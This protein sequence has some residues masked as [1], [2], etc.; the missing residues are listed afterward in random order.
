MNLWGIIKGLLVQDETDRSK[1]LSLEVDPTSTTGTKT[2]LK[3]AQTANRTLVLPD[4]SGTLVEQATTDA[5]DGR[6]DT[7]ESNI[8]NLQGRMT[9]AEGNITTNATN[10]SNHLAD[11]TDAHDASAISADTSGFLFS[12]AN[13]VQSVL[14]QLDNAIS[15]REQ[16][17][18]DHIG[19]TTNAHMASAVG[20]VPSGNLS[21]TTVQA[22]LNELQTE[23]DVLA[24]GGGANATLSNLSSPVAINQ[25]ILPDSTDTR[26][27]GNSPVNRFNNIFASVITVGNELQAGDDHG[28]GLFLG[29]A[30]AGETSLYSPSG[31]LTAY[32]T[33]TALRNVGVFTRSN[34]SGLAT[35]SGSLF[36]ETGN[37]TVGTGNS[38]NIQIRTGTATA[39]RGKIILQ[40]GT[41]GTS[42][43]VWTSSN[44]TGT[45]AW[46]AP[47]T[48]GVARVVGAL[49]SNNTSNSN[50]QI[51]IS[52]SS[53]I[54]ANS[55]NQIV[56]RN[57]TGTIVNNPSTSG[58]VANGRDQ[59]GA[60]SNSSWVHF[61]FIWN[62][63]TLAT[64]SS[65]SAPSTGPTLPSGYTH[66]AYV[67]SIYR[68]SGGNLKI[69]NQNGS[70]VSYDAR[71][72]LQTGTGAIVTTSVAA[73][74]PPTAMN[75]QVQYVGG[76]TSN[77]SGVI[78]TSFQIFSP[79][80]PATPVVPGGTIYTDDKR[81]TGLGASAQQIV[82]NGAV[83]IPYLDGSFRTGVS[84][85][86]GN[87]SSPSYTVYV[88]TYR[89]INGD[90]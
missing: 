62:G 74:V 8:T 69:I 39:T 3:A 48:I 45:G 88:N 57:S 82:W 23:I 55:S 54:L 76:L 65:A 63:T 85:V 50:T 66:F 28:D 90:N 31:Q 46:A 14:G 89:V 52:A 10:L 33:S 60:F 87:G 71:Q 64:I 24:P 32:A 86:V 35:D 11:T 15:V 43:H 4:T 84:T 58:P 16:E 7:A 79:P 2:V 41:E 22:A 75:Y 40:D 21:A 72:L 30:G 83:T 34:A 29:A 53:V 5:L 78:D 47:I 36:L 73:I 17:I 70:L 51:N 56:V 20:N 18:T 49:V 37:K 12:N 61:Y 44:T 9:T 77:A 13:E 59:A 25:D 6:L 1:Q 67:S 19:D 27:I 68:D 26:N 38:G 80:Y 42:G 81:L